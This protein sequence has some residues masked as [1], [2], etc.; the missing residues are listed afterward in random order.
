M[1]RLKDLNFFQ[2]WY[3]IN[4]VFLYQVARIS[5]QNLTETFCICV[6]VSIIFVL[7]LY[8][9][10]ISG[11]ENQGLSKHWAYSGCPYSLQNYRRPTVFIYWIKYSHT[12][13]DFSTTQCPRKLWIIIHRE[14]KDWADSLKT[15]F[16]FALEDDLSGYTARF[17]LLFPNCS[18]FSGLW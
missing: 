6:P 8:T 17:F 2:R 18:C 4:P 7:A 15:T 3:S 10:Q 1:L 16:T 11:K 9:L 14:V 12:T 5:L 13:S